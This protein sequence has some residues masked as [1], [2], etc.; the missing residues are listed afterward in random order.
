MLLE[1]RMLYLPSILTPQSSEVVIAQLL[2]LN[3]ENTD[4]PIHM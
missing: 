4:T 1:K 3:N 2:Y